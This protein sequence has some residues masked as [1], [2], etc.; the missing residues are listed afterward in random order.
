MVLKPGVKRN[1]G[2][3]KGILLASQFAPEW[4]RW[5]CNAGKPPSPRPVRLSSPCCVVDGHLVPSRRL[6]AFA[7]GGEGGLAT[8]EGGGP[9]RSPMASQGV[10]DKSRASPP[11][12][13]SPLNR[14]AT[15]A[16]SRTQLQGPPRCLAPGST[17]SAIGHLQRSSLGMGILPLCMGTG[18][19]R[20]DD[21]ALHPGHRRRRRLRA[22]ASSGLIVTCSSSSTDCARHCVRS[23]WVVAVTPRVQGPC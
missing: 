18:F 14:R 5:R 12:V 11:G 2:R 17:S 8:K 21:V 15:F 23:T 22:C 3:A 16:T 13:V 10:A 19:S 7:K 1:D 20:A 9:Q 4:Q 6:L